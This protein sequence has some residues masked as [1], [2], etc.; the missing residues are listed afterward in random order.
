MY[1]APQYCVADGAQRYSLDEHT[2]QGV[3]SAVTSVK[4]AAVP[5]RHDAPGTNTGAGWRVVV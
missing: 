1:C 5:D 3:Y 2:E 4:A